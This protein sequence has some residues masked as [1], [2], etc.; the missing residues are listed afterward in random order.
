MLSGLRVEGAQQRGARPVS[1][2]RV[3]G[4]GIVALCALAVFAG[5]AQADTPG[6]HAQRVCGKAPK[7][8]SATCM[9]LKL[10]P[11]SLTPAA[12]RAAVQRQHAVAQRA[13]S[14][15]R[16]HPLAEVEQK[17]PLAKGLTPALL[18]EAYG[19][20]AET[21]EGATQT[22]GIVDAFDDPTAESDLQVYDQE[23]G[24][25]ECT[26]ANGCF[27]K[28]NEEGSASPLPS[29]DGGWAGEISI[30]VQ[31]AHAICRNCKI[32]LV[33]SEGEEFSDLGASVDTAV[34]AGAT[35]VSNSYGDAERST[36]KTLSSDYMHPGTVITVS[37]GDCGYFN[38]AAG[39]RF[40]H[41]ANFP[42]DVPE[43]VAVGGTS[44]TK[45]GG[46][47]KSTVWKEGGSGCSAIFSAP[48]WQTGVADW[49]ETGCGSGRSVADVAA[50]GDPNT[51]VSTFDSTP[52]G[53]GDPTGWGIW[54]GTSVSS[55]II[56]GEYGLAGGA[57]GE[58]PPAEPLYAAI[59]NSSELYD[60]L[61]GTNGTCGGTI[62]CAA[63]VGYDGPTGVGSPIGLGAFAPSEVPANTTLPSVAGVAE[64]GQTLTV[65]QGQW[66]NAPTS[67]ADQWEDCN[68][69]GTSCSPIAGASGTTYKLTASDVGLT[70]RVR[71]MAGNEH[72][73]GS[74]ALSAK[75]ATVSS[76]APML[77]GFS[78]SNGVTGSAVTITGSA[79]DGV[80]EVL[81]GKLAASFTILSP[82]AIEAIVPNGA[83]SGKVTVFAGS[84]KVVT[85]AKFSVTASITGFS[86]AS[87]AAG[88]S[89]TIKGS[90]FTKGASVS[91]GGVAAT[92]VSFASAKKLTAV[93]PAGALSGP[94]TVTLTAGTLTSAGSFKVQ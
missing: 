88:K 75:T 92:S 56:A 48:L 79:L 7:P 80:T 53:E 51:G 66:S 9:S 81:V 3:H 45:T 5:A 65:T 31:M 24:L 26:S 55:P 57:P 71:E 27:K 2:L 52:D 32:I 73:T 41:A 87:G 60:V 35:I 14:E 93:V 94:V 29:V 78:P 58:E 89:V 47:W 12:R 74:A 30:D 4:A 25:P 40:G 49:A 44:L 91:F 20:P 10:V 33:E 70:V 61:S 46:V 1:R 34:A 6:Y 59:G 23:W 38:K 90:G 85:K 22:I 21:P 17:T 76:N 63:H 11:D 37:S 13:H 77:G 28:L 18:H 84:Q 62:A 8:G 16:A 19:L 42:A 15:H 82:T 54:G 86:P 67:I 69:A 50:V 64:Q 43:V 83:K 39:C 68:S 36:Y 72:G